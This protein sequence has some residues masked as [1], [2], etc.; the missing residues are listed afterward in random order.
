MHSQKH[1]AHVMRIIV[2]ICR[3]RRRAHWPILA[4]SV[5]LSSFPFPRYFGPLW[6][7]SPQAESGA[8]STCVYLPLETHSISLFL[9]LLGLFCALVYVCVLCEPTRRRSSHSFLCVFAILLPPLLTSRPGVVVEDAVPLGSRTARRLR[10]RAC[11][12]ACV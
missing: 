5:V 6:P 2:S 3:R 7:L 10:V 1:L 11:A 8:P 9:S 4:S 12:R